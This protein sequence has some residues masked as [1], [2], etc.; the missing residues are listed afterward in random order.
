MKKCYIR[1]IWI[2]THFKKIPLEQNR[3]VIIFLINLPSA[4]QIRRYGICI[5]RSCDRTTGQNYALQLHWFQHK[6]RLPDLISNTFAKQATLWCATFIPLS[7]YCDDRTP[8]HNEYF[9]AGVSTC[10]NH[11]ILVTW[12]ISNINTN[13]TVFTCLNRILF[14]NSI[15]WLFPMQC[16]CVSVGVFR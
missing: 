11:T 2:P 5:S 3:T 6:I 15:P 13:A 7:Y 4:T 12:H 14:Y 10:L 8:I 9:N 16:W 1:Q